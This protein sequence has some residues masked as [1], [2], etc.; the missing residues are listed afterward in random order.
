[1]R[2]VCDYLVELVYSS[3]WS[4]NKYEIRILSVI[5][6]FPDD[7][8]EVVILEV[9][10]MNFRGTGLTLDDRGYFFVYQN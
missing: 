2:K 4:R 1:M 10:Q 6:A 5:H 9:H 3:V 8:W 7:C